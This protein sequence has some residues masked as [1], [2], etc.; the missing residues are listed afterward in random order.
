MSVCPVTGI[1]ITLKIQMYLS[2][3]C[4]FKKTQRLLVSGGVSIW[5]VMTMAIRITFMILGSTEKGVVTCVG[6]GVR[7]VLLLPDLGI[8]E[9]KTCLPATTK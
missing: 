2:L 1:V 6:L 5:F 3:A 8:A 4:A 7:K 9:A